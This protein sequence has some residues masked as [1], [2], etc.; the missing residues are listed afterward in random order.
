[1]LA[2]ESGLKFEKYSYS[3]RNRLC[4]SQIID[5]REKTQSE[6]RYAY[7]AFGRRILVQDRDEAC[8]KSIYDGFTFDIIKQ[9]PTFANGMFTDSNETGLRISRTGRPTGDRYRYLEDD[10]ND[11]NRYY[12]IDEGNYKTVSSRYVGERTLINVNGVA[13]AQ[14][15]D[16]NISYFT[17]DLLGSV[18]ATTDNSA[19]ETDTYAYDAFGSLVQGDLSGAK[20]LGYLGKQFDKATGLY[21]YGYRDYKPDVARFT[22]QDPIRD[23]MNWYAYCGGDPINYIDENGLEATDKKKPA[24]YPTAGNAF[25]LDFGRDYSNMAVQNFK[26]GH[27]ILGTIQMLDSA[28]E[29]VYDL[30]AA[31]ECAQ[32]IGAAIEGVTALVS[33]GSVNSGI[34]TIK[35]YGPMNKGP[36]PDGMANTFRGGSYSQVT[37]QSDLTLYRVYGG[38]AEQLGSYWTKTAPKGPLQSTIDLALKPEWGNTAENVVK[39]NVPAGTTIFEGFAES[40]G[41]FLLGGGSQVVIPNV[42]PSWVVK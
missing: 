12:N 36:L 42:D 17:T 24:I 14:N 27:P 32:G 29:I 8:M 7:D 34:E 13:A 35:N 21:N 6:S 26:N 10:K 41:G 1:M 40:Q 5:K 2:R 20:D 3:S 28:C 39:I 16:G 33:T 31:Y 4:S 15:A 38:T 37:L 9:S 25:N 18:R 22:T 23:G 30:A 11:G 19:F